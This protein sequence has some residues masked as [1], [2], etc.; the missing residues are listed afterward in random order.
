MAAPQ[1]DQ[2]TVR[3]IVTLTA[4]KCFDW[5][6]ESIAETMAAVAAELARK[7]VTIRYEMDQEE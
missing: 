5:A 4:G 6:Q 7:A 1:P 3:E 2:E